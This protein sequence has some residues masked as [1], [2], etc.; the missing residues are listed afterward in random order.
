MSGERWV[1]FDLGNVIVPFDHARAGAALARHWLGPAAPESR[2]TAMQA[3]IQAFIF[4]EGRGGGRNGALDRGRRE[5]G[6]PYDLETLR[7]E[8]GPAFGRSIDRRV[9]E[10]IWCGIFD[11]PRPE[12]LDLMRDLRAAGFRIGVCS[13][14]NRAHW[15][16]CVAQADALRTL[17]DGLFLSFEMHLVKPEAAYFAR[18]IETTGA[19]PEDHVLLDDIEANVAAAIAAGM[20]GVVVTL[21]FDPA[22]VRAR[23]S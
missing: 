13:N 16:W 12:A 11:S 1:L 14:T 4:G 17:P 7:R 15:E 8:L 23:I 18:V 2:R 22:G 10:E 6:E 3:E 21:P 19:R 20:R 5:T 9:L